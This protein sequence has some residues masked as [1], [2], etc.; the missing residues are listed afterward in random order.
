[1]RP[2]VCCDA[3]ASPAYAV[4]LASQAEAKGIAIVSESFLEACESA[5]SLVDPA[6]HSLSPVA[7]PA[8][9]AKYATPASQKKAVAKEVSWYWAVC[10]AH[11]PT[12]ILLL[13]RDLFT[14]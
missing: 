12:Q 11:P 7:A 9:A 6:A 1:V 2:R 4:I 13:Q 5:G 8:A 14:V 10:Y 3:P